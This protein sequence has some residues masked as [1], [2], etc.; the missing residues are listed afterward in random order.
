MQYPLETLQRAK[1]AMHCSPF[2]MNLFAAMRFQSIA[3]HE[4][5]GQAGTQ[6]QYTRHPVPELAAEN[7]LIWFIQVGV[8]RR[9]VDGQG[10]TD[11]FRLTPLGRHLVEQWQREEKTWGSASLQDQLLNACRRWL[12]FPA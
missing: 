11:S 8:L 1:R 7:A 12:R 5:A 2:Q 9:E 10:L 6:R 4:I 3:L